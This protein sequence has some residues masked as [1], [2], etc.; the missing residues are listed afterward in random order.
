MLYYLSSP[1]DHLA[2]ALSDVYNTTLRETFEGGNFANWL[3][4]KIDPNQKKIT[5]ET[6]GGPQNLTFFYIY[7]PQKFPA[8]LYVH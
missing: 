8:T 3:A 1:V 7:I 5:D 2:H 4:I 6:K